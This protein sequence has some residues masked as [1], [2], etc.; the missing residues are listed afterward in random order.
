M[1][2]ISLHKPG[3]PGVGDVEKFVQ[4]RYTGVWRR[5][6]ACGKPVYQRPAFKGLSTVR[7][8]EK[9]SFNLSAKLSS[10]VR[11]AKRMYNHFPKSF[12]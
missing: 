12:I 10:G 5:F 1:R 11:V 2:L 8:V 6:E 4:A 3:I 9:V 7:F